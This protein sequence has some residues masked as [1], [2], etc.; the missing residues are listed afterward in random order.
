MARQ[1]GVDGVPYFLINSKYTVS[2]AQAP[3]TF[4]NVLKKAYNEQKIILNRIN[5]IRYGN[6]NSNLPFNI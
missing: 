4:L 1:L 5:F 3:D 6:S 2:G